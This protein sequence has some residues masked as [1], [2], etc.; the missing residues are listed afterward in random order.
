MK[1]QFNDY[2]TIEKCYIFTA[3]YKDF[4]EG[5]NW[6][7]SYF[8]LLSW[9]NTW[10]LCYDLDILSNRKDGAFVRIVTKTGKSDFKERMLQSLDELGYRNVVV[11]EVK[12]RIFDAY[13][14]WE[15]D[16]D[17]EVYEYFNE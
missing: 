9:K 15:E 7:N 3:Y 16:F 13:D 8:E 5:G 10:N 12:A 17:N 1:R 14:I 2:S 6:Q 11:D 4:I